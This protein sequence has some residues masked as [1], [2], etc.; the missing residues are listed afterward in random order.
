METKI[1]NADG[2]TAKD[3]NKLS[4]NTP[5]G[6]IDKIRDILF[7]NQMRD[8]DRRFSRLEERIQRENAEL[9]EEI[10]KRLDALE[11]YIRN[12]VDAVSSRLK[13]EQDERSA[14]VR[15]VAR[16][17]KDVTQALEKK[18]T[19]LDD[20]LNRNHR[21]IRQS[22]LDQSKQLMDEIQS[23]HN[24][25]SQALER[26]IHELTVDKMER[27]GLADLFTEMALRLNNQFYLDAGEVTGDE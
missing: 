17:L 2:N 13:S 3:L 11:S 20:Q 25:L 10:R 15:E 16:E 26:A 27:S 21:E 22:A 1:V 6:N 5:S 24:S 12:E 4:Q 18:T 14:T 7:G 9:K 23:K 8:Y 19:Q